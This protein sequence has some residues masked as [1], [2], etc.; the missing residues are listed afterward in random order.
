MSSMPIPTP[1]EFLS[2]KGCWNYCYFYRSG[3]HHASAID[4]FTFATSRLHYFNK[5]KQLQTW[6]NNPCQDA[7]GDRD[8]I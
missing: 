8:S 5:S 1:K 7:G 2:V 3:Q 6:Q 4:R